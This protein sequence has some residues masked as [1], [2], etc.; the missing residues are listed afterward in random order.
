MRRGFTLI[1]VLVTVVL[2]SL[3][4]LAVYYTYN[5]LFKASKE[6]TSI[7]ESEIERMI[8]SE[9][10]RLDIEHAGFG[11][12]ENE[13][14]PVLRWGSSF[15]SPPGCDDD[16]VAT[17]DILIIRSMINNT[18]TSETGWVYVDCSTGNWPTSAPYIV[19]ERL[20]KRNPKLIFLDSS[21]QNFVAT[22]NFGTCPGNGVYLAYP[23]SDIS[24][25][26][27]CIDQIY[28]H[29]IVYR[30]S[31][32]QNNPLC[33]PSTRNLLRGVDGTSDSGGEP[34]LNCIA[35]F[36]ALFDV[37]IDGDGISDLE[38]Q[39]YNALDIDNNG[40]VESSEV[41]RALKRVHLYFLI[42]IGKRNTKQVFN[43]ETLQLEEASTTVSFDLTE[44]PDYQHYRW[45]IFKMS[46]TPMNLRK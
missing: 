43:F 44:I 36:V 15:T 24:N 40:T 10:I 42:Q 22:G 27:N 23:Y 46:I 45:K 30:L 38:Y 2:V 8:G 34:V 35:G 18:S 12:S 33:N 39:P 25:M 14:C 1:E 17:E 6:E 32:S 5:N 11:I 28:C 19:D 21:T 4:M 37:D 9:I 3:I 7:S 26:N 29:R 31:S 16:I 41:M 20:N 13:T